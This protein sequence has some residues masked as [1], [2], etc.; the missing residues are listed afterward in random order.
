MFAVALQ[1]N[2]TNLCLKTLQSLDCVIFQFMR[3][4]EVIFVTKQRIFSGKIQAR[5]KSRRQL[6][7]QVW[8]QHSDYDPDEVSFPFC[9]ILWIQE[10]PLPPQ[11]P[12]L[13]LLRLSESLLFWFKI[14][15]RIHERLRSGDPRVSPHF[16]PVFYAN[17]FHNSIVP[18][19]RDP[20]EIHINLIL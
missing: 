3:N 19:P 12:S 13:V 1:T 9:F 14:F 6:Q 10:C 7:V 2:K 15:S 8:I 5:W 4:C 18:Q 17:W 11:C 16:L 20:S